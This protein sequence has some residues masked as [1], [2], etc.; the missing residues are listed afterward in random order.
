MDIAMSLVV[1]GILGGVVVAAL[2][3][4]LNRKITKHRLATRDDLAPMSPDMINMAHIRV[5]GVGG[6]GM[7]A[8]GLVVAVYLPEIGYSLAI[9]FGLGVVLAVGLVLWRSHAAPPPPSDHRPGASTT[10]S[11]DVPVEAPQ[12]HDPGRPRAERAAHPV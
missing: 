4:L 3:V 1:P 11:I 2:L 9:S 7:V 5:A 6:L 12:Q 10:L 8:T